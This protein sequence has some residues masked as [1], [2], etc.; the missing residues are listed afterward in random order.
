MGPEKAVDSV[1]V[2]CAFG[3]LAKV[4]I[5]VLVGYVCSSSWRD[6]RRDFAGAV[7]VDDFDGTVVTG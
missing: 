2:L 6:S 3:L 7:D 4:K 1:S 5:V